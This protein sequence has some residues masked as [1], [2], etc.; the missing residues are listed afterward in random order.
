MLTGTIPVTIF[1]HNL[2]ILIPSIINDGRS[3]EEPCLNAIVP[4]FVRSVVASVSGPNNGVVGSVMGRLGA[5]KANKLTRSSDV[6]PL[7]KEYFPTTR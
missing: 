3:P 2:A 1:D 7:R 6:V 5:V 4:A